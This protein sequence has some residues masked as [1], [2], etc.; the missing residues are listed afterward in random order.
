[1]LLRDDDES[2]EKFKALLLMSLLYQ[3]SFSTLYEG[4]GCISLSVGL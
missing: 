3:L 1:M 4:P 2:F